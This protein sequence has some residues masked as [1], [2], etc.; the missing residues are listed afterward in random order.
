MALNLE[1]VQAENSVS[2]VYER[3]LREEEGYVGEAEA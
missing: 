3:C 1:A 2:S